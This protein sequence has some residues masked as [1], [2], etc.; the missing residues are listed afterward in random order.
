ML[1]ALA[2]PVLT[3]PISRDATMYLADLRAGD[4]PLLA[5]NGSFFGRDPTVS[6]QNTIIRITVAGG[7][8]CCDTED[9]TDLTVPAVFFN[10]TEREG[11]TSNIPGD[12]ACF[13][14]MQLLLFRCIL[15]YSRQ[16]RTA[17]IIIFFSLT[18]ASYY[19]MIHSQR[20]QQ[21]CD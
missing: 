2:S 10:K 14:S 16:A 15:T 12:T 6:D 11:G 13:D 4:I 9:A 18:S 1:P 3:E 7:T 21:S 20:Q 8:P 17:L 19:C 5:V